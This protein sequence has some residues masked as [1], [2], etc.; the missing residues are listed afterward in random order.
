MK[1][2]E[3]SGNKI[4]MEQ[5]KATRVT[6]GEQKRDNFRCAR[7]TNTRGAGIPKDETIESMVEGMTEIENT[8]V[9]TTEIE[10]MDVEMIETGIIEEM[11][12]I[13][14][15]AEETIED[16]TIET[17]KKEKTITQI[18]GN[19]TGRNT[20]KKKEMTKKAVMT[21]IE[22]TTVIDE[23]TGTEETTEIEETTEVVEEVMTE[24]MTGE[25]EIEVMIGV[26][27]EEP[28]KKEKNW[29]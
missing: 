17:K 27:T 12:G 20:K 11:I 1:K 19:Q 29:S 14:I 8:D 16:E 28:H 5:A 2:E 26:V 21:K 23:M 4:D 25:T 3:A 7:K 15:T 13:E 22:G 9:G 10:T 6:I 18:K 24:V